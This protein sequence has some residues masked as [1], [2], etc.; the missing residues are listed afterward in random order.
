[1]RTGAASAAR[2]VGARRH[3][4]NNVTMTI[5]GLWRYGDWRHVATGCT[6]LVA[7]NVIVFILPQKW[8][9]WPLCVYP[10]WEVALYGRRR[11]RRRRR[12]NRRFVQRVVTKALRTLLVY[13]GKRNVSL[14][15]LKL[16]VLWDGSRKK[17]T[18]LDQRRR[19]LVD[20]MYWA[21]T[22]LSYVHECWAIEM[23]VGWLVGW[24]LTSLFST[25][26]A[27]SVTSQ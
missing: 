20:R 16:S 18:S 14:I 19:R 24:N 13:S 2:A 5:G 23:M 27:I 10:L 1:M 3:N 4:E 22:A 25:N 17:I 8:R 26:A 12:R 6:S 7:L 21:N 9:S 15:K 11:R